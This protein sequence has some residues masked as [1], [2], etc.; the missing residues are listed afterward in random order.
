MGFFSSI[1]Q[2]DERIIFNHFQ[3]WS[4]ATLHNKPAALIET[5]KTAKI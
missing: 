4:A 5:N 2:Y 3:N 1:I